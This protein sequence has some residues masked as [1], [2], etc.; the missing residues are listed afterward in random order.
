M[1]IEKKNQYA[2]KHVLIRKSRFL[3][4]VAGRF[5]D[6]SLIRSG[7]SKSADSGGIP[8]GIGGMPH[9]VIVSLGRGGRRRERGCKRWCLCHRR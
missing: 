1:N 7:L 8:W 3:Y 5:Y 4:I 6:H 9:A 2:K